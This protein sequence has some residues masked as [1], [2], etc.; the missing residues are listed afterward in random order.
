VRRER[1]PGARRKATLQTTESKLFD[2]VFYCKCYPTFD[3][4][5]VLLH[6]DRSQAE[7]TALTQDRVLCEH[8]VAGVNRSNSVAAIYRNR[9][10]DFD[11]RLMLIAAGLWN[12][13]LDTA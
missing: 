13:Y 2:S 11:D 5:S 3:L 8:A 1:A 7:N 9:G 12:F 10:T 4:A 6:F